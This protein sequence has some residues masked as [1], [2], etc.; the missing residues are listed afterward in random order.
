MLFLFRCDFDDRVE[1]PGKSGA[2]KDRD[3]DLKK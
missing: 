1:R 3:G 2:L